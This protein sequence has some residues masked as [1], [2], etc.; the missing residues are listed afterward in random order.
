MTA[1]LA[2]LVA[3]VARLM[4]PYEGSWSLCGGWAVDT[5]LG[6]TTR[7]HEDIDVAVFLDEQHLFAEQ[8]RDWRLV[9]H[10]TG[11]ADH[12]TLWDGHDLAFPSH[13]HAGRDVQPKRELHV[14]ERGEGTWTLRR[15]PRVALPQSRFAVPT[16]SGLPLL[17]PEAILFYKMVGDQRPRDLQD[18]TN[19]LPLLTDRQ[20]AWLREAVDLTKPDHPLLPHLR[21]PASALNVP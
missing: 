5:W 16:P 14:N 9:A 20:R 19:L 15:N 4:A 13:L 1:D 11:E 17:A 21:G 7:D 6:R 18:V 10:E 8:L 3:T 2:E 12:D